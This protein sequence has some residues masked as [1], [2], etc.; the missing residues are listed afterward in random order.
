MVLDK[1]VSCGPSIVPPTIPARRAYNNVLLVTA[2]HRKRINGN[3]PTTAKP[4]DTVIFKKSRSNI[5]QILTA[6]FGGDRPDM[7]Q[8]PDDHKEI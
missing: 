8:N 1:A 6:L 2:S 5:F 4:L 7:R 3:A